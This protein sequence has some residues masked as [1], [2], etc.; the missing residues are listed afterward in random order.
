MKAV[1]RWVVSALLILFAIWGIWFFSDI[2][3]YILISAVLSFMGHPLVRFFDGLHFRG[4]R[5][6]HSLSAG[7]A[8]IVELIVA[9]AIIGTLVPLV[10]RQASI[11]SDIDANTVA[12]AFREPLLWLEQIM[13]EYGLMDTADTLDS[14]VTSKLRDVFVAID[15]SQVLD[16]LFSLTGTVFI[17]LFSI[18]FITYFFLREKDLFQNGIM[19]LT[20]V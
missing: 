14:Y 3:L 15:F 2:V 19:L 6:P 12:Q 4:L 5:I 8:L 13:M 11:I 16:I 17:G 18:V 7:L 1:A 9:L 10:A 20:P